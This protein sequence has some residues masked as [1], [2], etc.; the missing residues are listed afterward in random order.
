MAC[1]G[2]RFACCPSPPS[3]DVSL[4]PRRLSPGGRLYTRG[5]WGGREFLLVDTGGLMSEAAKLPKE[6]QVQ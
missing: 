2:P 6:Q 4:L 5:W 1:D 3:P